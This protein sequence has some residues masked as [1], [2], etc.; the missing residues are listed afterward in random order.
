MDPVLGRS[1]QPSCPRPSTATVMTCSF[2]PSSARQSTASQVLPGARY[3]KLLQGCDKLVSCMARAFIEMNHRNT[4][5]QMLPQQTSDS[6]LRR[7]QA[8]VLG[9]MVGEME[10]QQREALIRHGAVRQ[11]RVLD[12]A[13]ASSPYARMSRPA[14]PPAEVAEMGASQPMSPTEASHQGAVRQ[15]K[16]KLGIHMEAAKVSMLRQQLE[17]QLR[18]NDEIEAEMARLRA[19]GEDIL[20]GLDEGTCRM[21]APLLKQ[22]VMG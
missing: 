20:R 18:Q 5:G 3:G 6:V 10:L 1:F 11:C 21:I 4:F 9:D 17:E 2:M 13:V 8:E 16:R 14:V 22:I 12:G 15:M 19:S 7:L